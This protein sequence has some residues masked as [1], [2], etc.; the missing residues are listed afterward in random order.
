[1]RETL[2]ILTDFYW[3]P[4]RAAG[5]TLDNGRLL[6]SIILLA[7]TAAV[8]PRVS[9]FDGVLFTLLTIGVFFV[10]ALIG[11]LRLWLHLGSFG[12]VMRRDYAPLLSCI[13]FAWVAAHLP[14]IP[15]L[16][17]GAPQ[18]N[19][20]LIILATTFCYWL[21]LS[22]CCARVVFGA[23]I[24]RAI[25][26]VAGAVAACIAGAFGYTL[27]GSGLWFL[28]SPWVLFFLYRTFAGEASQLGSG[29]SSRQHF[30]RCLEFATL[31][32]RDAD[33][34]YQLGLIYQSRRQYDEAISHYRLA[35]EISR[36]EADAHYQ[37]G[38]IAFEQDRHQEALDYFCNA[39]EIDD[40]HASNE[41]WKGI[42]IACFHLGQ[43]DDSVKALKRYVERREYDP[44]GL[45]WLGRV[46]VATNHKD[47]AV[48]NFKLAIE[49]VNSAPAHRRHVVG[50]WA[51]KAKAELKQLA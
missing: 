37:L 10:P 3:R 11:I 40:K 21:F 41:V 2:L 47:E 28:G 35:L 48:T 4:L 24:G 39:A 36:G 30:R 43:L 44:E 1:M 27:I 20:A 22:V 13:S 15:F 7:V 50:T 25:G 6:V 8:M 46:L 26:G 32:P 12:V 31:N 23:D 16:L 42:G 18:L 9:Q 29:L 14:A 34:H 5:R 45:Y 49:A 19:A 38:R 51:G 33:A 17:F